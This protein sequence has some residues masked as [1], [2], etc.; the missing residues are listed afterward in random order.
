MQIGC[1]IYP[2]RK[3]PTTNENYSRSF[4]NKL[5]IETNTVYWYSMKSVDPAQF[6]CLPTCDC[7]SKQW[8]KCLESHSSI[9]NLQL[10]QNT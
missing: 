10:P 8:T 5:D 2:I 7:L 9:E 1:A 3:P 4:G 6:F